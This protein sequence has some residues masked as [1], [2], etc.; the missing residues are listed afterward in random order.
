M[1]TLPSILLCAILVASSVFSPDQ[2]QHVAQRS[3]LPPWLTQVWGNHPVLLVI[4]SV[5]SALGVYSGLKEWFGKKLVEWVIGE[6]AGA[7]LTNILA[8]SSYRK[9]MSRLY[10]R[11]HLPFRPEEPIDVARIY[12]PLTA[13]V[14]FDK[15]VEGPGLDAETAVRRFQHV[16][17]LAPPGGGK[18]MLMRHIATQYAAHGMRSLKHLRVPILFELHKLNGS[19]KSLTEHLAAQ[20]HGPDVKPGFWNS[21]RFVTKGLDK[22]RLFILLDGL[23]EVDS[24]QRQRAIAEISELLQWRCNVVITCRT[25]VYNGEFDKHLKAIVRIREFDDKQ[26]SAFV[27]RWATD[28]DPSYAERSETLLRI[29]GEQPQLSAL[30]RNPLLLTIIAFVFVDKGKDLPHSRAEFY[31][32]ATSELLTGWKKDVY[33][34]RSTSEDDKR[35]AL[36][37]VATADWQVGEPRLT[38]TREAALAAIQTALP[39]LA[40]AS[41]LLREIVERSGLLATEDREESLRWMHMTFRE[42][43]VA[44]ALRRRSGECI[45]GAVE[46]PGKW[47]EIAK[48]WC[49]L[50]EDA[51]PVVRDILPSNPTL[52]ME[53][54]AE[55]RGV[56]DAIYQAIIPVIKSK[57]GTGISGF[58]M[59]AGMLSARKGAAEI[60]NV[61]KRQTGSEIETVRLA[62][63]LALSYSNTD[64]AAKLLASLA[65]TDSA[66]TPS[67][68]RMGN[69]A[70]SALAVLA[71]SGQE[72]AVAMMA[73]IGGELA[74]RHL[75]ALMTCADL[76]TDVNLTIATAAAWGIVSLSAEPAATAAL[77]KEIPR[78]DWPYEE[79]WEWV[80]SPFAAEEDGRRVQRIM[81]RAAFLIK[82]QP[83]PMHMPRRRLDPRL[84]VPLCMVCY[85]DTLRELGNAVELYTEFTG[86]QDSVEQHSFAALRFY[87]EATWRPSLHDTK[88]FKNAPPPL[89]AMLTAMKP[90]LEHEMILRCTKQRAGTQADWKR[91]FTQDHVGW[92]RSL[93]TP[94]EV[95]LTGLIAV[96]VIL[97]LGVAGPLIGFAV[98][99]LG[100]G[101]DKP[102]FVIGC[103]VVVIGGLIPLINRY[104]KSGI[105][106]KKPAETYMGCGCLSLYFLIP[107]SFLFSYL[108]DAAKEKPLAEIISELGSNLSW[109]RPTQPQF[110]LLLG[111]GAALWA[112]GKLRN[113]RPGLNPMYGL[114]ITDEEPAKVTPWQLAPVPE[115]EMFTSISLRKSA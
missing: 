73:D 85:G 61:L 100:H 6:G 18:S 74:I 7:L 23:D 60:L 81:A 57:I 49:G 36:E 25:A 82:T 112:F 63:A 88:T 8:I 59:A 31:R 104:A 45:T 66:F 40:S 86:A 114:P 24:S 94:A 42:Y 68:L 83:P 96:G 113:L 1:W 109:L 64:E 108:S 99:F 27:R 95:M 22:G 46:A 111:G 35:I 97:A 70:V 13:I 41:E 16:M 19:T 54:C 43:F 72:S 93:Q 11:A 53:C 106:M 34:E 103:W 71:I 52:A 98:T 17:V 51:S 89:R 3:D 55:A 29:L 10:G 2:A 69:Q 107:G 48:L 79:A 50:A 21:S 37:S 32:M 56:D 92:L 44:E 90:S 102:L 67:L 9:A 14:G 26:V 5:L 115:R 30:A 4:G 91:L 12:V 105:S 101:L 78:V 28:K 20:L 65:L 80:W 33:Q 87:D 38:I 39:S 84:L 47:A 77:S 110:W 76:M 75:V 62:A 15:V 58:E